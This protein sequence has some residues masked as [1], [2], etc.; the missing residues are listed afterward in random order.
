MYKTRAEEETL[1]IALMAS[2]LRPWSNLPD[3]ILVMVFKRLLHICDRIRFR[4]VCKGW[5]LP[6]S[7]P[8]PLKKRQ[9]TFQLLLSKE[10]QTTLAEC[11][12]PDS[13][14]NTSG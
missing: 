10:E 1:S 6:L 9:T 12:H 7:Y 8:D 4:A 11:R 13:L 5:R 2:L 3:E 14:H